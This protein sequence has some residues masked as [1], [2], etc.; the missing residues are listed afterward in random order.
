MKF[1]T[2][3]DIP[4]AVATVDYSSR[5][6]S[7]GSCFALSIGQKLQEFKFE[8]CVNPIGV[9]FNPLSICST[10]ERFAE[11]REID[12]SQLQQRGDEWFH[13]DFHGSLSATTPQETLDNINR[14]VYVGAEALETSDVVIITLGTAWVYELLESGRVVANCHKVPSKF[15]SR[16]AMGVEEVVERLGA[17]IATYPSKRFLLSVSPV[18]HLSDGLVENALS[19]ATLRVALARVEELYPNAHYFHAYEIMMD[20]LRDY[21]F[22]A[23]DMLHPSQVA[24]DY[25]WSKFCDSQIS[26]SSYAT[27]ESVGSIMRAAAHRPFNV[28]HSAHQA[29]CRTQLERIKEHPLIDF[30]KEYAYFMSQL[31]NNL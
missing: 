13:F 12:I 20:D 26:A 14:A 11:R 8:A 1:R 4:K 9:L 18:R 16:R 28:A 30:S 31:Q 10:L 21:R 29:F 7:L 15:F 23:D 6:L 25:I 19:K 27:M 24:V 2:E 17:Q 22:Y 5:I 3:I